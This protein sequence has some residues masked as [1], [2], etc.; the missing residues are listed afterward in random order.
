MR[1]SWLLAAA[2][3][4]VVGCV[5]LPQGP[6]VMVLPGAGKGLDQFTVDDA[7][8]RDW[9]ARQ[10]GTSPNRAANENAVTG[11]AVGTAVGA[12]TG[13]AVGAAAGSPAT[14]A[15]VGAGVGLL[16]GSVV[17]ASSAE[18]A[19]WTLQRRYDVAYTQCM[20]ARGNLVPVPRGSLSQPTWAPPRAR[21]AVDVPPPPPGAPPP[22]PPGE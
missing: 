5:R 19:R 7:V 12:A 4:C 2:G 17:G 14:G 11:A 20:Y 22:P 1:G 8:C 16:G 10:V 13:A 6:N 21:A 18:S 9:A 15:A 3:L